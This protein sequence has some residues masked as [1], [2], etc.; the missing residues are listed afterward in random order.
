MN[1]T[2]RQAIYVYHDPDGI[3]R[4]HASIYLE[5][6]KD[7]AS[8]VLLV[9]NGNLLEESRQKLEKMRIRWLVRENEGWDFSA[10]RAGLEHGGWWD[11]IPCFDELILCNCSCYGPF[12]RLADMFS[13]M[14]ARNCDFWGINR[15]PTA[16][17]KFIGE[18]GHT[19]PMLG[20]IQS[21]FYV[22]RRTAL[23][24][25][26]FRQWWSDLR[27]SCSYWDEVREHEMVFSSFLEQNGLVG[28]TF[29]D[30]EKYTRLEPEGDACYRRAIEQLARDNNP[31][32]KRKL[33]AE[34]SQESLAVLDVISRKTSYPLSAIAE[35]M[36]RRTPY[37]LLS[38][39]KYIIL[40]M[41]LP[42]RRRVYYRVKARKFALIRAYLNEKC[43]VNG[44]WRRCC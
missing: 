26:A 10:W 36:A 35:D 9:A 16:P 15:Q 21:Y 27:P 28:M 25:S 34:N 31:L 44:L 41:L 11:S 37:S 29:M 12:F 22:F 20:H 32:V 33:L 40:A 2:R 24:S 18:R 7:V 5:G 23:E 30:A 17:G 39:V 38:H 19:F 8:E 13:H 43:G 4:E 14:A 42:W 1:K 6:L 3:L